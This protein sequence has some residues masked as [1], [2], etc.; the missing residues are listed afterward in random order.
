MIHTTRRGAYKSLQYL[1]LVLLGF[2]LLVTPQSTVHSTHRHDNVRIVTTHP[3][4]V[5]KAVRV[6]SFAGIRQSSVV[7]FQNLVDAR[8]VQ[9][10]VL[11]ESEY[12]GNR[13]NK[14]RIPNKFIIIIITYFKKSSPAFSTTSV[15]LAVAASSAELLHPKAPTVASTDASTRRISST[16]SEHISK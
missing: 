14:S 6:E 13:V 8:E 12:D 16:L 10:H 5:V 11:F 7:L 9:V 3:R 1:S 15:S 2:H 4:L